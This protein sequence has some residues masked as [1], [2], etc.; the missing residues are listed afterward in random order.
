MNKI[1]QL[2]AEDAERLLSALGE[3]LHARNEHHTLVV[4]V[5]SALIVLGLVARATRT[6]SAS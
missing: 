3:Q 4:V 5:G 6:V 2:G 1:P